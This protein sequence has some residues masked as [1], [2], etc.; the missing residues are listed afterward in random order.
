MSYYYGDE[1]LPIENIKD[2]FLI[3]NKVVNQAGLLTGD[4]II[5]VDGKRI[6]DFSQV[7]ESVLFGKQ[8]LIERNGVQSNVTLPQD[9]LSQLID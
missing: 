8:I 4:K 6:E 1:I 9:L 2:G 3:E 7:S 5:A